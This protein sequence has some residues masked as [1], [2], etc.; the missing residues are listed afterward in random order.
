MENEHAGT[1][2]PPPP[3]RY[4][5]EGM[6]ARMQ[7]WEAPRVD[8]DN[9]TLLSF[10]VSDRDW[11]MTY[12]PQFQACVEAGTYSIMCSYNRFVHAQFPVP[13]KW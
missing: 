1:I 11:Y 5:P 3:L 4:S 7:R 10:K 6:A 9:T 8:R 13:T 12:L 2:I